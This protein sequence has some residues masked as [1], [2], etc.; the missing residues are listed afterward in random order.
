MPRVHSV[1]RKVVRQTA[2]NHRP[3]TARKAAYTVQHR[4]NHGTVK[5]FNALVQTPRSQIRH[6]HSQAQRTLNTLPSHLPNR[7]ALPLKGLVRRVS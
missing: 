1:A 2:E 7:M 3:S 5:R 6:S 4:A